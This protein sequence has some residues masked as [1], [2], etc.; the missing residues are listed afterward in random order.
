MAATFSDNISTF[1]ETYNK[2]SRQ[3]AMALDGVAAVQSGTRLEDDMLTIALAIAQERNTEPNVSA[4]IGATNLSKPN[5]LAAMTA[6]ENRGLFELS[7]AEKSS[8]RLTALG[9]AFVGE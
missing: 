5:F 1:L 8:L 6:G 7:G 9:R 2:L 3:R 4:L